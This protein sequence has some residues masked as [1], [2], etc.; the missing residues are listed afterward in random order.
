MDGSAPPNVPNVTAVHQFGTQTLALGPALVACIP[1]EKFPPQ[2]VTIDHFV[3]YAA[4]GS[5]AAPGATFV[6]QFYGQT[7]AMLAPFCSAR[8]RRRP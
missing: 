4:T 3:C 7:H 2:T 5:P 1:T 6:D 8:R